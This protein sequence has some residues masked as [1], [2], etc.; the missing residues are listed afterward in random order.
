MNLFSPS[1]G[2]LS[3]L[4]VSLPRRAN[5]TS[6]PCASFTR[7]SLPLVFPSGRLRSSRQIREPIAFIREAA[8]AF[9][10][11]K[12]EETGISAAH[13]SAPAPPF[14]PCPFLCAAAK[15]SRAGTHSAECIDAAPQRHVSSP[16]TPSG[17]E[18]DLA[19]RADTRA[20]AR[21][22]FDPDPRSFVGISPKL[23][24]ADASVCNPSAGGYRPDTERKKSGARCEENYLPG[25]FAR[26]TPRIYDRERRERE[27]YVSRVRRRRI[28]RE[29]TANVIA[30]GSYR[31]RRRP[32]CEHGRSRF[33][34]HSVNSGV[35][36]ADFFLSREEDAFWRIS[37][38]PIIAANQMTF[39]RSA[40]TFKTHRKFRRSA[41]R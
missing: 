12:R 27:Y 2:S 26:A 15:R 40:F 16:F 21:E 11:G 31:R 9:G 36:C 10:P 32:S 33:L 3:S 5:S 14:F 22:T 38:A 41:Q 6:S 37:P 35:R 28:S 25:I 18:N 29:V 4:G 24:S 1:L 19:P 20:R 23:A 7:P 8:S 17:N 34:P 30:E 13:P 39:L